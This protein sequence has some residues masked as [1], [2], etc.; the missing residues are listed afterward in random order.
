MV[1]FD[2][3]LKLLG[4]GFSPESL[5]FAWVVD[6]WRDVEVD[7]DFSFFIVES[8]ENETEPGHLFLREGLIESDVSD[9]PH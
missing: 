1:S 8:V 4:V 3:V 6:T 9:F 7:E 2:D 5:I